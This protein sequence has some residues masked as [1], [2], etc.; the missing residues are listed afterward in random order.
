VPLRPPLGEQG[1][2]RRIVGQRRLRSRPQAVDGD[3]HDACPGRLRGGQ[4]VAAALSPDLV[5]QRGSAELLDEDGDEDGGRWR[6]ASAQTA[7]IAA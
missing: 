6:I 3:R 4:Q 5:H 2:G 1:E 7:P